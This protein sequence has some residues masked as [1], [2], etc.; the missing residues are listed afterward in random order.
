MNLFEL[1]DIYVGR[2]YKN[3]AD[4]EQTKTMVP[5]W[6]NHC[7]VYYKGQVDTVGP[8]YGAIFNW[9]NSGVPRYG[10]QRH[11]PDT[12]RRVA[13]SVTVHTYQDEK[14]TATELGFLLTGATTN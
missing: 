9:A 10:A 1:E 7:L 4:E 5:V 14:V 8:N 12:E 13:S 6:S 2:Q 11:A 3:T